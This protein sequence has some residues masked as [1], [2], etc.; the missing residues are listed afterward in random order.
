MGANVNQIMS[1]S[2][3]PVQQAFEQDNRIIIDLII[4][5]A[6]LT[7]KNEKGEGIFNLASN[8]TAEYYHLQK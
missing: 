4:K 3:T 7:Y 2:S 1:D 8:G 6:D 5:D